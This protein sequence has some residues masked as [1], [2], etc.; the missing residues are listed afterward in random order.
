M[1]LKAHQ[2]VVWCLWNV[3]IKPIMFEV[4]VA[5]TL[6]RVTSTNQ[7]LL[8]Q[9]LAIVSAHPGLLLCVHTTVPETLKNAANFL[10]YF[11]MALNIHD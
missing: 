6:K 11:S 5:E 1:C 7:T 9:L 10:I 3:T 4:P 8:F 2:I